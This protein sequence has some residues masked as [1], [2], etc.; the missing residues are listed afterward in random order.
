MEEHGFEVLIFHAVGA[1]ETLETLVAEGYLSGLL[2]ITTT[3]WA[4]EIT[5]GVLSAGPDRYDEVYQKGIPQVIVPGCV[6]MVNFWARETVPE[7]FQDRLFN[8]WAP[9]V[10]LMRTNPEENAAIGRVLARKANQSRG[11]V[12]FFLPVKGVSMLDAPGKEFWWP[13]ADRALFDAVKNEVK[14][15]IPVYEMDYNINDPEFAE[16]VADKMLEFLRHSQSS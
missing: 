2:D 11:P 4:D 5:G 9:N 14:P 1:P 15:E 16:A 3:E 10:T 12:A 6:D 8:Q 7:R 13:E